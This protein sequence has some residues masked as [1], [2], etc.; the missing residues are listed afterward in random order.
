M[1]NKEGV[2]SIPFL[3]FVILISNLRETFTYVLVLFISM[4]IGII[5][6]TLG[7][8]RVKVGLLSIL[9]FL[10]SCLL[11][12]ITE[13][14]SVERKLI[15]TGTIERLLV[16]VPN[17]FLTFAF[18]Y[19]ISL[20]LIRTIQQLTLRQQPLKLFMYKT[21]LVVLSMT[22]L[23]SLCLVLYQSYVVYSKEGRKHESS[24]WKNSWFEDLAWESL[25]L[26][27]LVSISVLWRPRSNNTRYSYAEY[28]T[29]D[30]DDKTEGQ[31]DTQTLET[32][33]VIG[34]GGQLNQR[35]VITH[36]GLQQSDHSVP[37]ELGDEDVDLENDV[38]AKTPNLTDLERDLLTLELP[39]DES[40]GDLSVHTQINKMD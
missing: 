34:G 17:A 18:F 24:H 5:K 29:D 35:R 21:F 25:Y 8:T 3:S 7:T 22:A 9:Y 40:E 15:I 10:F 12:F 16:V 28:F 13:F 26:F 2:Y 20:S 31:E 11:Q 38:N 27:V 23:V 39:F 19:W 4:G 33:T 37:R 1:M 36:E 6:W 14:E 30:L 32:L